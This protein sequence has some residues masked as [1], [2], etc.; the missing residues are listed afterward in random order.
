MSITIDVESFEILEMVACLACLASSRAQKADRLDRSPTLSD[1]TPTRHNRK[2]L[3]V[4]ARVMT[5]GACRTTS[6]PLTPRVPMPMLTGPNRLII[7][8]KVGKVRKVGKVGKYGSRKA[9]HQYG[10]RQFEPTVLR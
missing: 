7:V 10:S 1:E 6:A 9:V 8:K 2:M 4:A 5:G 3:L